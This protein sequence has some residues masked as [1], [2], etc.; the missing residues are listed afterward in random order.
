VSWA[1]VSAGQTHLLTRHLKCWQRSEMPESNN[2]LTHRI[3]QT[4]PSDYYSFPYMS[5]QFL[6]PT[7]AK[8]R[9]F[10][11]LK[12]FMKQHSF[13]DDEKVICPANC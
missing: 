11:N 9:P 2:S 1:A 7:S 6:N 8:N 3:R 4:A 10:N 12:K 5:E 13:S